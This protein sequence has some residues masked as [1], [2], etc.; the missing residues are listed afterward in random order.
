MIETVVAWWRDLGSREQRVLAAG[1]AVILLVGAYVALWEPA[2]TGTRKLATALPQLRVQGA[3]MRAMADEATRL[4]GAGGPQAPIAPNDREAA[5]RRALDRAGLARASAGA[6]VAATGPLTTLSTGGV[7]VTA[8][9]S[10]TSASTSAPEVVAESGGRV[11]V[12]FANVDY[13][14]WVGWLASTEVELSTRAAQ[15]TVNALAPD[16][17]VGHV[18]SDVVFDWGAASASSGSSTNA[19]SR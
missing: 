9:S 2:A 12:R 3:A 5:V 17:P 18:R 13:G 14:V 19:A 4:R 15:V 8:G 1:I 7:V 16:G 10:A 6:S 11:R